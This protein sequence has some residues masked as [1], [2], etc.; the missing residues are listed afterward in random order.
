[1]ALSSD[2]FARRR[3]ALP[4]EHIRDAGLLLLL[5][6][7]YITRHFIRR[8]RTK[9]TRFRGLCYEIQRA[10]QAFF[11][12]R[13]RRATNCPICHATGKFEYRNKSTPLF[14]CRSCDHVYARDLPDDGELHALYG[15][16]SYWEKDRFHQGITAIQESEQWRI[17]LDARIGIL[18]K[19]GLMDPAPSRTKTVFEIGCAEGMLL[20]QLSKCGFEVAGCEMNRE[21][22]AQGQKNLGVKIL[23]EPFEETALTPQSFDLVMSFHTLEHMR[24][25]LDVL[26]KAAEILR[27]DGA[28]LIE[29]P[30]GEEEYENTD[31]LHFFSENSL[32]LLL[33]NHFDEAEIL[34]NGYT[35]S[36]GVA[37]G[38]IYGV[39][40][41]VRAIRS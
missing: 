30:C 24:H 23:T 12:C 26:A 4:S 8:L 36:S 39:G 31:H 3:V 6:W 2:I 16:F 5:I 20:H 37:I 7:I 32:R 34:P 18:Q 14:R 35:N 40:R 19:L 9:T 22:A 25:P 11:F 27:P 21:V 13:D 1:L 29:V 28:I 33:Q 38:S 41:R 15:D 17:Y 10:A